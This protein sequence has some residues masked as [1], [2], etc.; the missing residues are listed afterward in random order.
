MKYIVITAKHHDGF[1]MFD[2]KASSYN[3][4]AATPF[5]RDPLKE[6]AAACA[7]NGIR[8]GFYYSQAQDWHHPGGAASGGHWDKAQD[9]D[10]NHYIRTIAVPQVREILSNYGHVSVLWF[11]TPV[12]MTPERAA[13]FIPLMQLQPGLIVNNRL[14]GGFE[15]DTETPEQYIP[16]TGDPN[17][18]FEVCM[19]MNDTW[20]FKTDDHHWKSTAE[21][22]HNLIDIASKGGN[23]LLN[24]GPTSL[25]EIPEPSVE[26]LAA[27]GQ[28]MK[29]NG[30]AIYGTTASPF[31][32]YSFDGR[33]TM[34]ANR[35]FIHAF[36]W[37]RTGLRIKGLK[38]RVLSATFLADGTSASFTATTD[39]SGLPLLTI[40]PPSHPDPIATVIAL[41]LAS[42][43]EVDLRTQTL[44]PSDDGI[45]TLAAPDA[46]ISAPGAA[47]KGDY[48]GNW[49]NPHVSLAWTVHNVS[50]GEY[51]VEITYSCDN[52]D[53]G[54]TYEL[55]AGNS[56]LPGQIRPTGGW[57]YY[58]T[59]SLGNITL[60]PNATGN[61]ELTLKPTSMPHKAVMNLKEV[62]LTLVSPK[63]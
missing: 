25:G 38:T 40:Q 14:G 34:K 55:A 35:M 6:L 43:P 20:G 52:D 30:Q 28:W 3:I 29:T 47:L 8:L 17:R 9:G 54:S 61:L 62:K 44:Q 46:A 13:P 23:Y 41:D 26:R 21:L 31:R 39:K 11:D 37:P 4:V 5:H 12:D 7:K 56:K 51:A 50:A 16:A 60:A 2:S 22:L 42:A 15:G 19:T 58:T 63:Q 59:Q 36:S 18:D 1:A 24:V 45:I 49:Q 32:R 10:M 53:P 48:I 27:I 57:D 33:C